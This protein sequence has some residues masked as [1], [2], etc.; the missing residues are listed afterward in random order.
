[1][2]LD[3][4][5]IVISDA[6][7]DGSAQWAGVSLDEEFAQSHEGV[8]YD[9]TDDVATFESQEAY[10]EALEVDT[11]NVDPDSD[12]NSGTTDTTNGR[13]DKNSFNQGSSG[14]PSNTGDNDP[15]NTSGDTGGT[16][17]STDP[18]TE[19]SGGLG[20]LPGRISRMINRMSGS[21]SSEADS[22]SGNDV[23]TRTG[24][25]PSGRGYGGF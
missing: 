21:S 1:M 9:S 2:T 14:D 22:D 19:D 20:G 10:K 12:I 7:N 11:V 23:N 25:V 4:D 3:S 8:S 5:G 16:D 24:R 13:T 6:D 15:S 18:S 17:Q